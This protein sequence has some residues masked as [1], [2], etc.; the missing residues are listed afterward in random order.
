MYLI[1]TIPL[2]DGSRPPL[3]TWDFLTAPEG[4]CLCPEELH[5]I[6]YST[7]PAGFVNITV[8]NNIVTSMNINQKALDTYVASLPEPSDSLENE[9][10]GTPVDPIIV[11][12]EE[13]K[14]LKAKIT[15]LEEQSMILEE[16]IVEMANKIYE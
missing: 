16:C 9:E 7:S 4:Y 8:E 15:A 14:Q 6:F 5:D 12:Q 2:E 11:L 13:N 1:K 10:S 3:Q